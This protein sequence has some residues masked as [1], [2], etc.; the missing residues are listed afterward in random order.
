M[1]KLDIEREKKKKSIKI[2]QI[3]PKFSLHYNDDDFMKTK[4]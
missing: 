2:K 1:Q 4:W 3:E